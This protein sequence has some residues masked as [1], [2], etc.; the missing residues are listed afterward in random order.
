MAKA[1]VMIAPATMAWKAETIWTLPPL[2]SLKTATLIYTKPHPMIAVPMKK[3]PC[4]MVLRI[5][6]SVPSAS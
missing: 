3:T 5:E 2:V 4:E 6:G 1:T